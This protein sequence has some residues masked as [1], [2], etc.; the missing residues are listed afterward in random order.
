MKQW[1]FKIKK[2]CS[3]KYLKPW[4]INWTVTDLQAVHKWDTFQKNLFALQYTNIDKVEISHCFRINL[5]VFVFYS[6]AW[7]RGYVKSFASWN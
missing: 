3:A 2:L 4:L 7:E 1:N 6:W 5:V